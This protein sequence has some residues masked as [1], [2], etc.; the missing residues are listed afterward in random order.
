V[1]P[2]RPGVVL[3]YGGQPVGPHLIRRAKQAGARV[4]F[5]LHNLAYRGADFLHEADARWVPSGFARDAYRAAGVEA[6]AV[7]WPWDRARATADVTGGQ[8]VTFVNPQPG[9]GVAAFARIAR[10]LAGRRPD[11][12]FL[13]VEE[14][15]RTGRPG[16]RRKSP[17]PETSTDCPRPRGRRSSTPDRG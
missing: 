6:E 3:T 12:R 17:R 7:P 10:E 13:V 1:H 5:A 15:E 9:K 8:Y 16:S 4:V 14:R 11:I 2:V